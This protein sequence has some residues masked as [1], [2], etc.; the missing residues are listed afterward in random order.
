MCRKTSE[1]LDDP[2]SQPRVQR[3]RAVHF[4]VNSPKRSSPVHRTT[5]QPSTS[6]SHQ[7]PASKWNLDHP[8]VGPN[9]PAWRFDANSSIG[10]DAG[11]GGKSEHQ[12]GMEEGDQIHHAD[13][14]VWYTLFI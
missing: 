5:Q 11:G 12:E 2:S 14:K 7:S 4:D 1:D 13:G 3:K 6:P 8:A 9:S 10:S